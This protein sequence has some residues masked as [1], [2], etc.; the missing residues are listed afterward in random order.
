MRYGYM[1][2]LGGD[3]EIAEALARGAGDTLRLLPAGPSSDA[4]RRVAMM[5]H[6]PEEWARMTRKARKKY[7]R[8]RAPE[9]AVRALLAGYGLIC[10]GVSRAWGRL[11]AAVGM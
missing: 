9:G 2:K 7:G 4:V 5:Q 6:T 11:L 8:N 1:I 3:R 10:Y